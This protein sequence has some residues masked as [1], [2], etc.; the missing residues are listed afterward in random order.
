M[1]IVFIS[2]THNQHNY[3]KIPDCD[4]LIHAGDFTRAGKEK[5]CVKFLN[6]YGSLSQAQH[7]L[8][9]AGNHDWHFAR[10]PQAARELVPDSV[11]YLQDEEVV[12]DGVKFYGSPWQPAFF[13]WAFNLPRGKPL[14]KVWSRIPDDVNVLVTHTPPYGFGDWV[15]RDGG[16]HVGCQDLSERIENLSDLRLHAY[17][18]IHEGYGVVSFGDQHFINAASLD[19]HYNVRNMRTPIVWEL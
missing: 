13:D 6:W 16:L 17:G 2:D 1:R 3:L 18:H 5:E 9:I 4:V 8:V 15:R 19:E 10:F 7:K 12:I 14:Q 11:T